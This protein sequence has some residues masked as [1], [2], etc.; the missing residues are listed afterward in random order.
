MDHN[1]FTTDD[2]ELILGLYVDDMIIISKDPSITER[3]VES[4][5]RLWDIKDMGEV[6]TNLGLSIERECKR[7]MITISQILYIED[8]QPL[9]PEGGRASATAINGQKHIG[10]NTARRTTN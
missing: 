6:F 9:Q 1:V 10:R 2:K 8:T 7:H 4:I 3:T 5:R